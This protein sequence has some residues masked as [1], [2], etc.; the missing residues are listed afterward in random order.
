MKANFVKICA[1]LLGLVVCAAAQDIAPSLLGVKPPFLLVFGCFAGIPA[2]L[3]AGLFT[4]ALGGLPFGCSAVFCAGA[5][6]CARLSK[7]MACLVAI[8]AAVLYQFWIALWSGGGGTLYAIAG[9]L[10]TAMILSP[11]MSAVIRLARRRIGIDVRRE[12]P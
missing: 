7:S 1:V 4:D 8:V 11:L 3:C 10:I 9:T 2:A 6:F 5:A 12:G